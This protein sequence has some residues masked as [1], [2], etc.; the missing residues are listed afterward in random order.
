MLEGIR[1]VLLCMLE[2]PQVMRCVRLRMLEAVE[3]VLCLLE[4]VGGAGGDA[5]CAILYA[6]GAG[7]AGGDALCAT[8]YAGDCGECASCAEVVEVVVGVA[9]IVLKVVGGRA[10]GGGGCVEG[11]GSC[12]EGA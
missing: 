8:L 6:G 1:R 3:G 11:S 4:N 10:E 12:A 9:E 5:R 7:V 2:L